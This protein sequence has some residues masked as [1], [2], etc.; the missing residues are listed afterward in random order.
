MGRGALSKE[1]VSIL[2]ENKYVI[3]VYENRV[4]Y[5]KNLKDFFIKKYLEGM[6]PKKIFIEAGFD[7]EI[8]GSKRI[9]RAAA[10]WREM[11]HI[12]VADRGSR[13]S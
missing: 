10:R 5:S 1:E 3:D 13:K 11:A 2:K 12:K 8:L 9:E 7:P 6:R 4:F